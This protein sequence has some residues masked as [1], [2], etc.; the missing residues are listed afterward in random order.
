[1]KTS[2]AGVPPCR[3]PAGAVFVLI[4]AAVTMATT[5]CLTATSMVASSAYRKA[6]VY[7][8]SNAYVPVVPEVA[9][10]RGVAALAGLE[11]VEITAVDE[12]TT[13]CTA[14]QGDRVLTF[15]VFESTSGRSRLSLLVG[16]GDD[17]DTNQRLADELMEKICGRF[18]GGCE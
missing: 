5:G 8:T 18:S 6:S 9:F 12:V 7:G 4:V 1:M 10:E 13:R 15:R 17:A 3:S 16:G 2:V 14:D 11:D